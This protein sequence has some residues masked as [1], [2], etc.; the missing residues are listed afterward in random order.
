MTAYTPSD[1]FLE[2]FA[3]EYETISDYLD[4]TI[5]WLSEDMNGEDALFM[6]RR[7]E[8]GESGRSG[9]EEGHDA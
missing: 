8:L 7:L 2:K 6:H 5:T 1:S 4:D 9:S 3:P